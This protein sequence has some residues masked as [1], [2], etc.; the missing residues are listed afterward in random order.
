MGF[1]AQRDS[2]YLAADLLIRF[3]LSGF[4]VEGK[5]HPRSRPD[6]R[7][8]GVPCERNVVQ[9]RKLDSLGRRE[10]RP[11]GN[12]PLLVRN[13]GYSSTLAIRRPGYSR[14]RY[15]LNSVRR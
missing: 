6:K 3:Q 1:L 7:D 4:G 14:R 11:L 10:L 9:M 12:S 13:N 8:P 2:A 5:Q 15:D